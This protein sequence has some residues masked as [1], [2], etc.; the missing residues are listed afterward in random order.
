MRAFALNWTFWANGSTILPL[1]FEIWDSVTRGSQSLVVVI[2]IFISFVFFQ[3]FPRTRGQQSIPHGRSLSPPC[4][5]LVFLVL[6]AKRVN[7]LPPPVEMEFYLSVLCTLFAQRGNSFQQLEAIFFHPLCLSLLPSAPA[8]SSMRICCCRCC[9]IGVVVN[10]FFV[11]FDAIAVCKGK[12]LFGCIH[13]QFPS[14]IRTAQRVFTVAGARN[15]YW[16]EIPSNK[17]KRRHHHET[18]MQMWCL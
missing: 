2:Q 10:G 17:V 9:W 11:I 15:V 14:P 18:R 16:T 5:L 1:Q 7:L 4:A 8:C 6:V 3:S 13:D 12:Q